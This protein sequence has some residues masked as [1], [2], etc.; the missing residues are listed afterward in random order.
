MLIGFDTHF[1]GL[2]KHFVAAQ[3][4]QL[5]REAT[6]IYMFWPM[7]L[8]KV[9][10]YNPKAKLLI[11]LHDPVVRA[12]SHYRIQV[13]RGSRRQASIRAIRE[14]RKRLACLPWHAAPF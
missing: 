2:G 4:N 12:Y 8:E 6:P 3:T 13:A 9:L 14:G 10:R 7:A 11:V 1:R 5:C